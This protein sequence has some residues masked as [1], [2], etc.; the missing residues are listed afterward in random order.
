MWVKVNGEPTALTDGCT[1]AELISQMGLQDR[2]I[3]VEW[4]EEIVPRS[5]HSTTVLVDGDE[6]EIV[7]AIGGG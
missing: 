3:A 5:E 4:N 1:V 2:R 7:H 6:L